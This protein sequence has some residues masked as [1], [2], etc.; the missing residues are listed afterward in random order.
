[1]N[2]KIQ[3]YKMHRTAMDQTDVALFDHHVMKMLLLFG[4]DDKT[5]DFKKYFINEWAYCHRAGLGINMNKCLEV[6]QNLQAY[7]PQRQG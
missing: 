1:M 5:K 6:F 4:K 2:I 7:I 3:V